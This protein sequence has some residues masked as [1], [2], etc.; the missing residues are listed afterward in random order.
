MK[1]RLAYWFLLVANRLDKEIT[2]EKC[3]HVEGYT[4]KKIG[5][6]LEIS[7]KDVKK[8]GDGKMSLRQRQ[9]GILKDAKKQIRDEVVKIIDH[10][11]LI[12]YDVRKDGDGYVVSGELKVNV[13][14]Q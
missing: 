5:M 9:Q 6:S 7:K 1:K 2:I 13:P 12:E 10:Y 4:P 14:W 3:K 8:Y 11:H